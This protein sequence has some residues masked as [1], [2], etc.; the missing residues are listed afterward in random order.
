MRRPLP[1]LSDGLARYQAFWNE[2]LASLDAFVT[3]RGKAGKPS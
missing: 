3:R 1:K 2:Q